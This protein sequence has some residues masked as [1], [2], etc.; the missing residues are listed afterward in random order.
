MSFDLF[1]NS[2]SR[3]EPA[4][5]NREA[6]EAY[7]ASVGAR[8]EEGRLFGDDGEGNELFGF[9]PWRDGEPW[10][11]GAQLI[12]RTLN[13]G[14]VEFVYGFAAAARLAICNPQ[15]QGEEP[16]WILPPFVSADDLPPGNR[17]IQRVVH[18]SS[19]RELAEALITDFTT[20][21]A[22]RNAVTELFGDE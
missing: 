13:Q 17:E 14:I 16:M 20:F 18:I 2:F 3:S 4:E 10:T 5:A 11:G 9:V 21:E 1:L 15:F 7:L 12:V 8:V 19:G 22:I 6:G